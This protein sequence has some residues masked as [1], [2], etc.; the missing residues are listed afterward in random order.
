MAANGSPEPIFYTDK[1]QVLFM[2]T[3]P[4]HPELQ[5]TISVTKSG[6]KLTSADIELIEFLAEP[7][8]RSEILNLLEIGNQTKNFTTNITPLLK[9]GIIELTI[10]DKPQ[11]RLQKYRLTEKGKK[12]LK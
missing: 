4:C 11:S 7:K 9:N 10:A 2:V 12:L 8:S 1:D 6:I 3:L 5:G